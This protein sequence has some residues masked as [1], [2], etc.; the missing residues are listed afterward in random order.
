VLVVV[1]EAYF[2]Y[3]TDPEYADSMKHL[4]EG[5]NII[6][7]RTFSKIYGLA[8]LRIG[9]A[10]TKPEIAAEMNKIRNPFNTSAI[11]QTAAIAALDDDEHVANS[12][13]V[14]T[15]ER[16]Y[17]YRELDALG[18]RY[19]PTEANFIFMWP[20]APATDVYDALLRKGIIVRPAS[21]EAIR[22]T[23]GLHEENVRF[24]EGMKAIAG[25]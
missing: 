18:I 20:G 1:D 10:V 3:V 6:I 9:Y 15:E 16:E 17:L 12:K 8:G 21:E 14:N 5:R 7:L 25:K 4:R 22:V 23:I 2:E 24:I 19:V 13:R 11:A